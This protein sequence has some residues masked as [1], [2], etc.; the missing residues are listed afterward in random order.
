MLQFHELTVQLP[1]IVRLLPQ[2]GAKPLQ[3]ITETTL[4]PGGK[5]VRLLIVGF[6]YERN[7]AV[8]FRAV[9]ATNPGLATGAPAPAQVRLASA[10]HGSTDA[11]INYFDAPASLQSYPDHIWTGDLGPLEAAILDDPP[12][13][14][15]FIVLYDHRRQLRNDRAGGQSRGALAACAAAA[16]SISLTESPPWQWISTM[17]LARQAI[18]TPNSSATA[19]TN[20][21][22]SFRCA[23]NKPPR[24]H[25][26]GPA[27]FSL[28]VKFQGR[29]SVQWG[30]VS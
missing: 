26:H 24:C 30:S 19:W 16:P 3:G 2:P 15:S 10:V 1:A 27:W 17:S 29:Y 22:Q 6:D 28:P 20:P 12:D 9:A 5:P 7:K 11:P 14:A 4:G 13:A 8:Y 23:S 25:T 21:L 18:S